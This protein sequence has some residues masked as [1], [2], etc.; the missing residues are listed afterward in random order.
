MVPDIVQRGPL[1]VTL[2]IQVGQTGMSGLGVRA[3]DKVKVRDFTLEL[4][5]H[6][7]VS[8]GSVRIY[9]PKSKVQF[10]DAEAMGKLRRTWTL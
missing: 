6:L 4:N 8:L 2:R 7:V 1:N 9:S 5:D 10:A 3:G